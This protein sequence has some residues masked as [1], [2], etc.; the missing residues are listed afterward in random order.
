MTAMSE[1][2]GS[3][4][5]SLC[6]LLAEI[7]GAA[8]EIRDWLPLPLV[9]TALGIIWQTYRTERKERSEERAAALAR[10]EALAERVIRIEEGRTILDGEVREILREVREHLVR[11][12]DRPRGRPR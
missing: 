2:A 10:S 11:D 8:K 1:A 3:I 5:S 7:D 6:P 12:Q 9:L 4:I